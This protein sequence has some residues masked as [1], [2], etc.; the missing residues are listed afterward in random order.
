MAHTYFGDLI[1]VRNFDH[2]W[3]KES[4]AT[5]FE[6]LWIESHMDAD[7]FRFEML[8]EKRLYIQEV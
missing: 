2:T 8:D 5:Y 4:W 1:V 3:L 7:T 6:A